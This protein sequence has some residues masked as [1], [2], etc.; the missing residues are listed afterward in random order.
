MNERSLRFITFEG[1]IG[2]G[3]TSLARRVAD[4]LGYE[5]VLERAEE[6]PFLER[7]YKDPTNAALPTQLYF[8]FQRARQIQGLRQND[9]FAPVRVS[10]FLLE[11]DRLFAQLTLADDEYRLYEQVYEQMSI[12]APVPDL[13]V[14]MQAPVEVLVE[15]VQTR[16]IEYEKQISAD[17]L[18]RLNEAYMEFFHRYDNAPLL[19]VNTASIDPIH[20]DADYDQLLDR[21]LNAGSGREYFNPV[22]FV[23]A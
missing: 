19:I 1:P 12:D 7:F 5:L 22:P 11:K 6:N 20:N 23:T 2:V 9:M 4:S 10:D 15:R 18:R 3:K 8:L 17:Y 13:V 16:G 14:Y 21:I